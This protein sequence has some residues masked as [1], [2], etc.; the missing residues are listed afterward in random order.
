M[1]WEP[2]GKNV[3]VYGINSTILLNVVN[4]TRARLKM[5]MHLLREKIPEDSTMWQA[6]HGYLRGVV[7][8]IQQDSDQFASRRRILYSKRNTSDDGKASMEVLK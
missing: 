6:V 8:V 4:G 2:G 5:K 3:D 7:L 1:P